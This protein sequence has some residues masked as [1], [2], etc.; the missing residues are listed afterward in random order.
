MFFSSIRHF[1]VVRARVIPRAFGSVARREPA[2]DSL[3]KFWALADARGMFSGG[4]KWQVRSG[5]DSE[6]VESSQHM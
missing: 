5:R 2:R 6:R 3:R 1:I 4:L